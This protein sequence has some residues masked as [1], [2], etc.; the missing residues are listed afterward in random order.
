M[1]TKHFTFFTYLLEQ[2]PIE[3]PEIYLQ[4]QS[5]EDYLDSIWEFVQQYAIHFYNFNP[6][7]FSVWACLNLVKDFIDSDLWKEL[8]G[9]FQIYKVDFSMARNNTEYPDMLFTINICN[10]NRKHPALS[11]DMG[12][13]MTRLSDYDHMKEEVLAD[14]CKNFWSNIR[15]NHESGNT[16]IDIHQVITA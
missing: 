4:G 13:L 5:R 3:I 14:D 10:K 8:Q 9:V 16:F 15:Y 2:S 12:T 1:D 7:D 6:E 11:F